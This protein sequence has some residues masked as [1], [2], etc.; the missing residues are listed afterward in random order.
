[1]ENKHR[2]RTLSRAILCICL[3]A[4][5]AGG[6]VLL[7]FWLGVS[8]TPKKSEELDGVEIESYIEYGENASIAVH[9][10]KTGRNPVDVQVLRYIDD[11]LAAFRNK[12]E[13]SSANRYNELNVSFDVYRYSPEIISFK[14]N[15]YTYTAAD[16]GAAGSLR[17]M[18]FNL[19]SDVRYELQDLFGSV[20]YLQTLSAKAAAA[21]QASAAIQP[22]HMQLDAQLEPAPENFRYFVLDG[23][24]LRLF[25][26][27]RRTDGTAGPTESVSIPL[28][29]LNDVLADPFRTRSDAEEP[30][31]PVPEK[32]AVPPSLPGDDPYKVLTDTGLADK[33]LVALTFDDGP[34]PETTSQLLDILKEEQV[35]A[36]FFV[37]G[38]RAQYY[39]ELVRRAKD[40]GH[41]IGTHTYGHKLLTK[42]TDEERRSEIDRANE[43][44]EAATGAPPT[45]LRPPYGSYNDAVKADANMPV[46]MWSVDPEDWKYRDADTVCENILSAVEDGDIVLLH[47]IYQTSVEGAHKAIQALKEDGYTFVTV[48]QLLNARG[49]AES[50]EVYSAMHR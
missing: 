20:D 43:A 39:P 30:E 12:V 11:T 16:G 31:P 37:L 10:P 27:T 7:L 35:H 13:Q 5:A 26:P 19:D 23:Q 41:Q 38:S 40:E 25:F 22:G 49:E 6:T 2:E 50:G 24:N 9:Y 1:M 29:A 21:L 3:I 46:V 4:L 8:R 42:L 17:T 36:T 15:T 28:S 44:I 45:A 18:T 32:P 48:E 14:F 33:K 47:D 34:N